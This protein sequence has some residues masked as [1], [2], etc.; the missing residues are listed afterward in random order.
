[1]PASG[2]LFGRWTPWV[3]SLILVA[4][5]ASVLLYQVHSL[6]GM[7][8]AAGLVGLAGLA[9][10]YR[11][12]FLPLALLV[13]VA[14]FNYG[15]PMAGAVLK[16]SEGLVALMVAVALM[17]LAAGDRDLLWRVRRTTAVLVALVLL[18]V[19]AVATAAPHPN[20]FNVRYEVQNL[21]VFAYGLLVFQRRHWPWLFGLFAVALAVESVAALGLKYGLGLTGLNFASEG[22]GIQTVSLTAE[23]LESFAGGMFRISGTFGHK[24]LLA[25]FI[26][27]LMPLVGLEALRRGRP[28]GF[29][30]LLPA[31]VTLALTD[32]LT[33][34]GAM[35]IVLVLALIHLRRFDYLALICLLLI[36]M[37]AAGLIKFGE[38]VFYRIEQLF[39]GQEGWGT[40]SSREVI[41]S[42]SFD[43]IERFP[44]LGIGRNNF[45]FYGETFYAHGHNLFLMKLIEMGIPAGLMFIAFIVGV[46]ARTWQPLLQ[47]AQRLGARNEYYRYLGL[48]L[49]C[50]GFLAMNMLDY[51]YANFSLGPL[52]MMALG[53]CLS[54]AMRLER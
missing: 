53:I 27:L 24:N 17:R 14:P 54:V 39:A 1:M 50:L 21:I 34:W 52:F 15:R 28:S 19:L 20:F 10:A 3:G 13:L 2:E 46:M 12:P 43:L 51:N 44:W 6:L 36:P 42:I 47:E 33:G 41:Y 26:V 9:L 8:W 11:F 7:L 4:G 18:A 37:L 22:G 35:V 5:V 45:S 30:V 38:S 23:E 49:G 29:V 40:V 16:M 25:A 48:W 31:L 32:S